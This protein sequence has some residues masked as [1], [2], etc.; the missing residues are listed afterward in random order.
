MRLFP[1]LFISHLKILHTVISLFLEKKVMG[2]I[3]HKN[4]PKSRNWVNIRSKMLVYIVLRI[5]QNLI[6]IFT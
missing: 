1:L 2:P 5:S 6:T 3:F 4:I